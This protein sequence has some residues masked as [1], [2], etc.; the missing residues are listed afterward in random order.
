VLLRKAA[1]LTSLRRTQWKDAPALRELQR[2]ALVR[3]VEHAYRTVP[4]YRE[5]FAAAG[6]RPDH[7][8]DLPDLAALPITRK[9]DLAG[10]PLEYRVSRQYSGP[11]L[12]T[13]RS[14]GTTGEPVDF[15]C[16][17]THFDRRGASILRTFLANGYRLRDDIASLTR[18]PFQRRY[19]HP[20]LRLYHRVEIPFE[21]PIAEQVRQIR[22]LSPR[23]VEGYASWVAQLARALLA[24]RAED[25]RP[26]LVVTNSEQL[27]D[28]MREDIRRAFHVDATD[29]YDTWEF[30]N[31]AWQCPTRRGLHVNADLL[32]VEVLAGAREAESGK[33]GEIVVTDL[34]NRGAPLLRYALGDMAVRAEEPCPCG[35]ELPRLESLQGRT[36]EMLVGAD[37]AEIAATTVIAGLMRRF[38]G[39]VEYQACQDAPGQLEFRVVI[40]PRSPVWPE[41][42]VERELRVLFRIEELTIQRVM[43]IERGPS[44][45][46][47]PIVSRVGASRRDGLWQNGPAQGRRGAAGEGA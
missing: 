22:D 31:V 2:C 47:R 19:P 16:D 38:P 39:V 42:E 43:Q 28:G 15:P 20:R 12:I 21:A 14:S 3:I 25:V 46:I 9:S 7:V 32:L 44:G 34:R 24:S 17:R 10:V 26:Y 37:G 33:I 40:D 41:A 45:K 11:N 18:T 13:L 36:S 35:R 6:L 5:R 27:T 1:L 23:V 4:Y 29:V 30:G 8:R